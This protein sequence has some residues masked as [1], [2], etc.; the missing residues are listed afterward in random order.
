MANIVWIITF[1]RPG[2]PTQQLL[3]ELAIRVIVVYVFT[4]T[5]SKKE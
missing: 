2:M 4:G 1:N 5:H 3:D